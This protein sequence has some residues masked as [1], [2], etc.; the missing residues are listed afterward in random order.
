M[1]QLSMRFPL[2]FVFVALPCA[3]QVKAPPLPDA[4]PKISQGLTLTCTADGKSDAR[5]ARLVALYVPAGQPVTPFLPAGPFIARWEGGIQSSLRSEYTFAADVKGSFKLTINGKPVLEGA[6]DST[7]QS[8]NKTF[9]LNK[10]ANAFVA[11]FV[12]DGKSDALLRLNWWSKEFPAEPVPPTVFTHNANGRDIRHGTR[13]REG[14][15]LFAQLRCGA[16]HSDASLPAKGEGM[17]ELSQDAPLFDELGSKYNEPWLAHWI[18]DPHS[19]RP[20]SLMPRIFHSSGEGIDQRAADLAAYLTSIGKRDET[21][22]AAENA[23]LGGALFANLGCIACHTTPDFEGADEHA[24]VPLSHLKAKWQPRALRE[25]LKEPAKNY[26]WSHMPNFRLTD[27]EAERL[28]AYL[29]SGR[30]REFTAGRAGD[31][32]KGAQLLVTAGCLNCHAAVPPTTQPSLASTMQKGWSAGCMG[33]DPAKQG[34]APDFKMT[35]AQRDA[36]RAFAAAGFASLKLDSPV[37][38]AERVFSDMRCAACHSRDG[39][40]SVWAKLETEMAPLIAAAPAQPEGAPPVAGVGAPMS[41][42]FGE[43]LRPAWM[44]QFIAGTIGYKPRPW[45]IARMPGFVT[46]AAG[47]AQGFS[48]EHGFGL[49]PDPEEAIDAEKVKAG[50][51]LLGENGGFNC[52]TCHA[53]GDRPATAVFEAPGLNFADSHERLRPEYYQR[54]VL[55][56]LRIDPETKMPKFAD[57]EGKTPLTGF[58]DGDARKQFD[59]IWQYLRTVKK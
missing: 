7:S 25:Y 59:A 15:K 21:K 33:D 6:G 40:Q 5:K 24:R 41:T 11:E 35:A 9:Q 49:T 18:N 20:G 58:F 28:T 14:R 38:F 36:L 12:S 3:A 39:E 22:P 48:F 54:W 46:P 1:T 4:P 2:L 47:V 42:W 16:C 52:I 26:A 43:K 51:V 57:D 10:G 27:E 50:E 8:V 13:L 23:P 56:P 31:V 32:A 17:P 53:V 44:E 55:H 29:V 34:N 37:E 19:I 30:Q 45:L